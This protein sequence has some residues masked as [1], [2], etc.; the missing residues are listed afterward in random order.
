MFFC[1]ED[2]R[3]I[4]DV[5]IVKIPN[6]DG[7]EYKFFELITTTLP[8]PPYLLPEALKSRC[9]KLPVGSLSGK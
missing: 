4:Q 1:P 9:G 7:K 6:V 5:H 2:H 8:A 3:A